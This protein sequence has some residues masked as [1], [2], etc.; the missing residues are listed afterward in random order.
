M[1]VSMSNSA[2]K[3][4]FI[5]MWLVIAVSIAGGC[6]DIYG[7]DEF[8]KLV[9]NKPATEV[10]KNLGK[11]IA[12]DNSDPARVM[13]TYNQLTYDIENQNKRDTKTVLV[14]APDNATKG[15]KVVEVKYE[16]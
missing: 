10:E 9:I 2:L 14:L 6:G 13:W 15:L 4:M 5:G 7:H 16:R 12:V 8:Q 1:I 3:R 11:P